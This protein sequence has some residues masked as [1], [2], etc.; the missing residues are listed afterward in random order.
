MIKLRLAP[1]DIAVIMEEGAIQRQV[2]VLRTGVESKLL[3]SPTWRSIEDIADAIGWLIITNF[4]LL[5]YL[6]LLL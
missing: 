5:Y 2:Q 4:P 1:I 3:A 6:C